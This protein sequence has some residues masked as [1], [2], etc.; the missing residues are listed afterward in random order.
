[1][2]GVAAAYLRDELAGDDEGAGVARFLIDGLGE[3]QTAAVA[4][5]VLA[6]AGLAPRISV[7]F[8]T[9]VFGSSDLPR[10]VLTEQTATFYRDADCDREAYLVTS[11]GEEGEGQSLQD[12]SRLGAAELFERMAY[13]V[14]AIDE[15]LGLDVDAR[16]VFERALTGLVQLRFDLARPLCG[17]CFARP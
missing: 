4:R 2:D 10:E 14:E 15:R 16:M 6:D 7:K 8:P 5:A 17:L 9:D 3:A 11:I 1:M 13:W 12:M